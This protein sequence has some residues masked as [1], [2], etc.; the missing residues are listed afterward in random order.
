MII[1]TIFHLKNIFFHV[2]LFFVHGTDLWE[3]R[4]D[5]NLRDEALQEVHDAAPGVDAVGSIQDDHNVQ[6]LR[7]LWNEKSQLST[8]Y[9]WSVSCVL[10][11]SLNFGWLVSLKYLISLEREKLDY[12]THPA[13][14]LFT[15]VCAHRRH[16][17]G[18]PNQTV[19]MKSSAFPNC[20]SGI[21]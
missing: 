4:P 10:R 11:T 3:F 1:I 5:V 20:G 9:V 19:I 8:S 16:E 14:F 2:I 6:L 21:N 15:P 12:A 18:S 13:V 7:T 17:T